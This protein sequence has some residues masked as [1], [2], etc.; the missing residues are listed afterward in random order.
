MF[1]LIEKHLQEADVV[2]TCAFHP[3]LGFPMIY[4]YRP[5]LGSDR[6]YSFS[7][8]DFEALEESV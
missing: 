3:D 1:D 5:T 7:I 2:V 6:E 8:S 4:E